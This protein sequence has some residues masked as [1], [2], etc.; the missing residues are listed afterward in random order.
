M[1]KK[2]GVLRDAF[3]AERLADLRQGEFLAAKQLVSMIGLHAWMEKN[4]AGL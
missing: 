1:T 3:I 2:H 4:R